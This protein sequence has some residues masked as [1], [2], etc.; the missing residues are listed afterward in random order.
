AR[1]HRGGAHA[2]ERGLPAAPP[3]RGQPGHAAAQEVGG[4]A[5]K[6]IEGMLSS[7][8]FKV[9][10]V[11][12]R[13]NAFIVDRLV[14]GALDALRRTGADDDD[15]TV[16]RVPGS[17]EIPQAAARIV[18]AGGYDAVICLGCVVRGETPHFDYIAGEATK[19]VGLVAARASIPVAFGIL[20][21]E[22]V[23]Q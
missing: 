5:M 9:A 21:T 10:I 4:Q 23:E 17:F 1:A 20:T 8:G 11:A 2:R 7:A 3:S 19:G 12:S 22:T 13:F 18:D 15:L 6:K 16:C 14:D